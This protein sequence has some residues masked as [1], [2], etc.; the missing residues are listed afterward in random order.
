MMPR[1]FGCFFRAL[2]VPYVCASVFAADPRGDAPNAGLRSPEEQRA[3]FH[4][5]PGFEIQ[6]VATEPEIQK[7]M[8]VAFDSAGRVW[9]TG[10]TLYPWPARRDAVGEPIAA[11][12]KNWDDNNLAFRASSTPPEPAE[13]GLDSVRVLADFDPA[14][15]RARK[16]TVF[17]DGLN[18]PIGVLPLPRAPGAK[19]DT[20]LVYSI[21]AIWRLTDTDGDG[22]ADVR[23]KL[24]DGFGF[25]DT[26]GMSSSY[27]LWFDG[28]VYGTHGFANASEV[29]D[30]GG[31]TVKIT[32]GN[33]YRFR[34]DGSRFEIVANGQTN[35]FGLAFD[36]RG[37]LYTADSHSKPVYL[38]VPGGY[39]EG[40]SKE[41]DGLGFAPAIT[42]D[43]HGS[44]S[45][46]GIAHYSAAQFPPEFR[47]NLF[48]GNPVT[49][50]INRARLEWRGSTPAA[51]RQTDFLTS[52]DPAFRPVQVKLGPDGALWVADFYN[53]I[54][55]HYEVPLTHPARDRAHGRLWRIVWRGLDGTAPRTE[56]PNLAK[57]TMADLVPRLSDAN[58][59]VRSLAAA[60]LV[61]R[62]DAAASVP[63]LTVAARRLIA[64]ADTAA[65]GTAALA[66]FLTLE[67]LGGADAALLRSAL[68]RPESEVAV[69]A[70]RA[71]Q[72]RPALAAGEGEWWAKTIMQTANFSLW[73]QGA[74]LFA[75]DPQPWKA[76]VLLAM[77]LGA[78]SFDTELIYALKLA[79]KGHLA[80]ATAAEMVA[81]ADSVAKGS[82]KEAHRLVADVCLAVRTP[83]AAQFL[84]GHL[85]R[86]QMAEPR[87]AELARHAV[88][89][90]PVAELPAILP[91]LSSLEKAPRGQRLTLAEG[92]A[93]IAAKAEAVLP[94]E[95]DAWLRGELL[96][97]IEES[98]AAL[99]LRGVNA[100]KPLAWPEK[101]APLRRV[102]LDAKAR[103]NVRTAAVRA[104]DPAA[105]GTVETWIAA[106]TQ[107]AAAAQTLRR[108]AAE[109]LGP[110]S[111]TAEV[112]A[113][114]VG[115]LPGASADLALTVVTALAKS[116]AGATELL[117]LAA[118]GRVRAALLRHR[119]V[120]L[121]LER[122]PAELRERVAGLTKSL[123]PEDARLDA[124]VAYRVGSLGSFKADRGR[125]AALFTANCA[126]CHRF[127]DAGGNL[128]PSLDGIGSRALP[129]LVEDIL[130][131]NRNV[132]PTFRLTTVALKSGET[133]T[134]MDFRAE[135]DHVRLR[136]AG[137]GAEI[138]V[139]KREVADSV[140]SATSPMP[141]AFETVLS[142]QE[143]ADLVDYLRN[144]GK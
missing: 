75:A 135:D 79:L 71:Y 70:L 87:A 33:T 16:V 81:L 82:A 28:W 128:G 98:D 20:A 119:Y 130:D 93:S 62:A 111:A 46:S 143:F 21:P 120:A 13:H 60:E 44:S 124:L 25:K 140:P 61:A 132:D 112:R 32:S 96:P 131:P 73:R 116:D 101:A 129:R 9:V 141:A 36:A 24:Y 83:A 34:P 4:L 107:S 52:D 56:L 5:P 37:D 49:R 41:H 64:G 106:L 57:L 104:L 118:A 45:I 51:A 102:A 136:D 105:L 76:E 133:K 17:A 27:W 22:R 48:N 2:A 15:G 92:L 6:L 142:E 31:R 65:D 10:S 67:R 139:A 121:A 144:P 69:A 103:E 23:E 30:R 123:P 88:Q 134:G 63:A 66:I 108:A 137:T 114:L 35:P 94:A 90:L 3:L 53:P 11:F 47:D 95:I 12:Q 100:V 18:I 99:A 39:Y 122:R 113:A 59:V 14:T 19:G 125:G 78:P 117:E 86:T 127:R 77:L 50:R 91:L 55:G 97:A 54:I 29:V 42:T 126:V 43:D 85:Q 26:H 110:S 58:L 68:A 138:I 84:I 7:P 40:I 72:L 74:A 8:N 115:A 1:P 80:T 109:L 38:L 89:N